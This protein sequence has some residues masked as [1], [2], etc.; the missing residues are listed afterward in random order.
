MEANVVDKEQVELE[1][2]RDF[3]FRVNRRPRLDIVPS[4]EER[5]FWGKTFSNSN[6][7]TLYSWRNEWVKNTKANL[8]HF[9]YLN[10]DHSVK[11]ILN[12]LRNQPCILVGAGPSLAKNIKYLKLA[13]EKGIPIIA[14]SHSVMYLAQED[15]NITPDYVVVLDAGAS[16]DDYFLNTKL[17]LKNVPLLADM[18]C[19]AEQLKK[20][21]G[22]VYFYHSASPDGSNVAKFVKMEIDRIVNPYDKPSIIEVHGHVMGAMTTLA[23]SLMQSNTLIYVGSDYCFD[24]AAKFY[25]FDFTI[26]KEV[27]GAAFGKPGQLRNPAPKQDTHVKDIFGNLLT[28]SGQY[29]GFKNILDWVIKS[30]KEA[31]PGTELEFINATEGGLMGALDTGLSKY[32]RYLTLEDAIYMAEAKRAKLKV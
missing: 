2:K 17:N 24:R 1:L 27:D 26:D 9:K 19:N 31:M 29:L 15:V 12:E 28:S 20:W 23:M 13:K 16:W 4:E 8:E 14:C 25:P 18:T 10:K 30:T 5:E 11:V 32:M 7:L 21:E 22:P 6:D 3:Y